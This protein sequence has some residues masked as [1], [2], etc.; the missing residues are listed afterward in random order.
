MPC[1]SHA[2]SRL[3][4]L[5]DNNL[6]RGVR[7]H[8]ILAVLVPLLAIWRAGSLGRNNHFGGLV[9]KLAVLFSVVQ[10]HIVDFALKNT[11]PSS[12]NFGRHLA[13]HARFYLSLT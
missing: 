2:C 11:V 12:V 7:D 8:V 10:V 3:S 4:G 5:L 1:N 13:I 6:L 9:V